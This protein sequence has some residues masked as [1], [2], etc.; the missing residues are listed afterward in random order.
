MKTDYKVLIVDDH[1][2]I[3]QAYKNAF[4]KYS[5][6]GYTFDFMQAGNCKDGYD[7][8]MD[9]SNSFDLALFDLSMPEYPEKNIKSGEDLAILIKT[10]MP[11]C[12]S[13]VLTMHT[14]P[15]RIN[16]IIKN[17]NP[18]GL[19]IKNDITFDELIV[20]I[21]RVLNGGNYYTQTI[22]DIIGA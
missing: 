19:I 4:K 20:A 9:S 7:L 18:G 5:L 14:E 11:E 13:I 1:P 21:D 12:R 17:I 15:D 22:I 16:G 8:I 3:I 6:Q 10:Q 2:F